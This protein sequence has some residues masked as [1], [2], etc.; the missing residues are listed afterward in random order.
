MISSDLFVWQVSKTYEKDN[1]LYDVIMNLS[2]CISVQRGREKEGGELDV[3]SSLQ[4][5]LCRH[6]RR[7]LKRREYKKIDDVK[8]NVKKQYIWMNESAASTTTV[9]RTIEEAVRE[10]W[11]RKKKEKE[12]AH[13]AHKPR[14]VVFFLLLLLSRHVYTFVHML[15]LTFF[16]FLL[17]IKQLN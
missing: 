4:T 9:G 6:I 3:C 7:I 11:N 1:R 13:L 2:I 16:H 14:F 5:F 17:N 10:M 15:L 8:R 12:H